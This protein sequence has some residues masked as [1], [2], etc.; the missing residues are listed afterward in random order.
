MTKAIKIIL[1]DDQVVVR[2]AIGHWLS[3]Q[4][5]IELV[6][7]ASSMPELIKLLL[8]KRIDVLVLEH[9]MPRIDDIDNVMLMRQRF[10]WIRVLILSNLE[11]SGYIKKA[12]SSDV[13]GY[14]GKSGELKELMEA[15]KVVASGKKYV[16]E[17]LK[18]R[19][20]R[21]SATSTAPVHMT[22]KELNLIQHILEGNTNKEISEK[23]GIS[24][25]TVE[26][27]RTN[28][29]RKLKIKNV[30]HLIKYIHSTE[31][32]SIRV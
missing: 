1:A 30:A 18:P 24:L 9:T 31:N 29:F 2:Q 12:M 25:K 28:I 3:S 14:I 15:I 5:G 7:E 22:V 32:L 20:N 21:Q 16:S 23:L 26:S 8:S 4:N 27:H 17:R 19:S 10:P 6:G 13:L 11:Q